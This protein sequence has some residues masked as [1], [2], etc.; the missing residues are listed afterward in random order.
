MEESKKKDEQ[1]RVRSLEYQLEI[2][3]L[4]A[5]RT[6]VKSISKRRNRDWRSLS[7]RLDYY[8]RLERQESLELPLF[9]DDPSQIVSLWTNR[10]RSTVVRR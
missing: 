3:L 5:T 8:E 10:C 2:I 4:G 1:S 7:S 6:S 9:D